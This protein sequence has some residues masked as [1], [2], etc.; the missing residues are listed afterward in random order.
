MSYVLHPNSYDFD[1]PGVRG[2]FPVENRQ[3]LE[4]LIAEFEIKSVIEVGTFLGLSAAWFAKRV[5]RVTCIDR[6][7]E[8]EAEPSTNNLVD[9]IN[10]GEIP[11]DFFDVFKDSMQ[12][13]GV[14]EKL[15]II[16]GDSK[17]VSCW[18][19]PADLVYIDGDHSYDGCLK[20]IQLYA[21]KSLRIV[22][23]DDY[24]DHPGF[25][26][27]RAVRDGFPNSLVDVTSPPFWWTLA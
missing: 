18:A 8:P 21:P 6:W 26:V 15:H 1:L 25:G 2:W 9:H 7:Y 5:E 11:R 24:L 13:A 12:Q 14:W 10:N 27:K 17:E 19:D 20:D 23:G 16:R 4:Q 3:V 22:C